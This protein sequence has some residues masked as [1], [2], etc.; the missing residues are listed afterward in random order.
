ML[1]FSLG[2]VIIIP[3]IDTIKSAKI[4]VFYGVRLC[5]TLFLQPIKRPK[6]RFTNSFIRMSQMK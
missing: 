2:L 1:T 4:Q 5:L 6:N 3:P